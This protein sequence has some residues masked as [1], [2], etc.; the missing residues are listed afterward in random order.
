MEFFKHGITLIFVLLPVSA[1]PES[2]MLGYM[3]SGVKLG[4]DVDALQEIRPKAFESE[5]PVKGYNDGKILMEVD[6]SGKVPSAY[7]YYLIDGKLSGIMRGIKVNEGSESIGISKML[8]DN[9][10][11]QAEHDV[12]RSDEELN[13]KLL[14]ATHWTS[15]NGDQ[16]IIFLADKDESTLVLFDRS[17]LNIDNFFVPASQKKIHDKHSESLKEILQGYGIDLRVSSNDEPEPVRAVEEAQPILDE[18]KVQSE[19]KPTIEFA[20]S[21][22][23]KPA[24]VEQPKTVAQNQPATNE[25]ILAEEEKDNNTLLYLL[26]ALAAIGGL[27]FAIMRKK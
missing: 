8:S 16:N 20:P 15:N 12:L 6:R 13:N 22:Q 1:L 5:L 23:S 10:K 18:L 26:I 21:E 7:W 17:Q 14:K 24:A 3:P 19:P 27:F 2:G 25:P 11:M 9:Y 4:I